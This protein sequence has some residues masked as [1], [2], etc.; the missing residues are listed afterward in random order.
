M[1]LL[2][3]CL[4]IWGVLSAL[5]QLGVL[6]PVDLVLYGAKFGVLRACF[7]FCCGL[8]AAAGSEC[9]VQRSDNFLFCC[10]LRDVP[11]SGRWVLGTYAALSDLTIAPPF[12]LP[13]AKIGAEV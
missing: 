2:F 9:G 8:W 6:V 1:T 3:F 10:G 4:K 13:I 11:V 12:I 7:L 5:G